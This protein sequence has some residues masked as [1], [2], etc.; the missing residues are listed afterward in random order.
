MTSG[1]IV[2]RNNTKFK[3][4]SKVIID[5]LNHACCLNQKNN[6]VFVKYGIQKSMFVQ[7]EL[8]LEQ[9]QLQVL[10]KNIFLHKSQI[11]VCDDNK[12]LELTFV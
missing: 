1:I 11:T 8:I 2:D 4:N 6:P 9:T 10:L 12:I 3:N 5:P 7:M